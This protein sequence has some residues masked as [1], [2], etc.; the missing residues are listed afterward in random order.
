MAKKKTKIFAS[1][2]GNP[3]HGQTKPDTR[4]K[5]NLKKKGK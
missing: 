1:S 4:R 3:W 5:L 2:I